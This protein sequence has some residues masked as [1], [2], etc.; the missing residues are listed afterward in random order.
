MTYGAM[1]V[2]HACFVIFERKWHVM[3]LDTREGSGG[4]SVQRLWALMP[5]ANLLTL[6]FMVE[7]WWAEHLLWRVATVNTRKGRG[8]FVKQLLALVSRAV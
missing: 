5:Y 6:I 4:E 7:W 3:T 1:Y 8:L 2:T